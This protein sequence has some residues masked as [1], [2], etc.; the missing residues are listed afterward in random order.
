MRTKSRQSPTPCCHND[1]RGGDGCGPCMRK[2]GL[3]LIFAALAVPAPAY[4]QLPPGSP[5]QWVPR[6]VLQA[7]APA[8]RDSHIVAQA[9]AM[10]PATAEE[11]TSPPAPGG[12]TPA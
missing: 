10:A 1:L 12:Y 6:D 7:R 5:D 3:P 11:T 8:R 4:G 9:G 2:L